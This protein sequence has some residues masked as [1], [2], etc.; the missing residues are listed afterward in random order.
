MNKL[1]VYLDKLSVQLITFMTTKWFI[2]KYY[3][4][5]H[6]DLLENPSFIQQQQKHEF[7]GK[8]VFFCLT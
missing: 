2:G 1:R 4:S 3:V 6:H 5:N 8:T 7:S